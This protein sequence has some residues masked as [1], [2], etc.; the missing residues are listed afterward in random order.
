MI[1]EFHN[2]LPTSLLTGACIT[3]VVS[4]LHSPHVRSADARKMYVAAA[5]FEVSKKCCKVCLLQPSL[6]QNLL[7][8]RSF[9]NSV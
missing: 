8:F 6:L 9:A 5:V 4:R 1:V 7:E 2:H 3:Y